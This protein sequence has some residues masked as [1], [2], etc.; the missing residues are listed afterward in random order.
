M[1]HAWEAGIGKT[2]PIKGSEER[3]SAWAA[4]RITP[5]SLKQ[6]YDDAVAARANSRDHG[7]VNAPFLQKFIDRMLTKPAR[8]T[9][10]NDSCAWLLSWSG[11][12]AKGSELGL[13]GSG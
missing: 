1:L 2:W 11:I 12:C 3:I 5:A 13:S 4:A 7:P 9:T 6:A 8:A 10:N